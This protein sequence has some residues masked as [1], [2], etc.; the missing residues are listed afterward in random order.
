MEYCSTFYN[1]QLLPVTKHFETYGNISLIYYIAYRGSNDNNLKFFFGCYNT[2]IL[3]MGCF[4]PV[5]TPWICL[6]H[7]RGLIVRDP[8]LPSRVRT[9]DPFRIQRLLFSPA[10]YFSLSA[11]SVPFV[12][13]WRN[14]IPIALL[15]RTSSRASPIGHTSIALSHPTLCSQIMQG[16]QYQF[17]AS[18]IGMGVS[19]FLSRCQVFQLREVERNH[20]LPFKNPYYFPVSGLLGFGSLNL[21][22]VRV[23]YLFS[24]SGP[25]GATASL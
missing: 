18:A 24:S 7:Y 9:A 23:T 19:I 25:L 21:Q 4:F 6:P 1:K 8:R 15:N 12:S 3:K 16:Y 13:S 20:H 17:Y 22:T 2:I 14:L 11:V 10:A 5:D